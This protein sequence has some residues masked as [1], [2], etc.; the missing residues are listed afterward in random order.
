MVCH[1]GRV[2]LHHAVLALL[3]EGPSHGYD[4][5]GE[6]EALVGPHFGTL[7]I[8]HLY[9]LLERLARDG[10]AE[11]RRVPQEGR[12]DRLVHTLTEA[13]RT[14]LE[15]WFATPVK[16]A[17]GYRDDFF[18]KVAAARRLG[19]VGLVVRVVEQRRDVLLAELRD[20]VA[21]RAAG[22]GSTYDALLTAAAELSVQGQLELLDR[23]QD[24]A[25]A[26]VAEA[27]GSWPEGIDEAE[28]PMA[29]VGA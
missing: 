21:L 23:M 2:P 27:A 25:P 12:P 14:E 6:F 16:P 1:D 4:L 15:K 13:G 22:G 20:L 8:G 10:L 26:L 24:A 17:A 29:A 11:A 19:D 9:Q 5:K 3:N 18:L 7:N 28:P